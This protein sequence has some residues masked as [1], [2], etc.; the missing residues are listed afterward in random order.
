MTVSAIQPSEADACQATIMTAGRIHPIH[1]RPCGTPGRRIAAKSRGQTLAA[2][3]SAMSVNP[4]SR[5]PPQRAA[6]LGVALPRPNNVPDPD[7]RRN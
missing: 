3:L 2:G 4:V 7:R 6:A 1:A 5:A